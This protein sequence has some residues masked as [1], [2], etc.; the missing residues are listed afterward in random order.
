[1][2][3]HESVRNG[4]ILLL[5]SSCLKIQSIRNLFCVFMRNYKILNSLYNP[6]RMLRNRKLEFHSLKKRNVRFES[7]V[8]S[9]DYN[10]TGSSAIEFLK[11]ISQ[12]RRSFGLNHFAFFLS[13]S[14]LQDRT[15][16][17]RRKKMFFTG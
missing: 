1:M 10:R 9:K 8:A 3:F 15:L 7:G 6:A 16:S 5:V 12:K 2:I 14:F 11:K 13:E 4:P 17:I